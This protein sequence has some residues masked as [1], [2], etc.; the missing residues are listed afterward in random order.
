VAPG[1]EARFHYLDA[2]RAALMFMG[3]FVHSALGDD[4]VFRGI[5]HLSGLF[6][7]NGFFLI[8]G[9]FSSMLVLRYGPRL[10]VRRRLLSLGVPLLTAGAVCNPVAWWLIYNQYN[11]ALGFVDFLTGHGRTRHP[12]GPLTWHLQLWFL[13]SL[14]GYALATPSL[15][16]G[17]RRLAVARWFRRATAS[18]ARAQATL[19]GLVLAMTAV[20]E[21][22]Y[23]AVFVPVLGMTPVDYVLRETLLY[24]PFFAVGMSLF[25]DGQRLLG[26]F[27]RPAPALFAGA[28]LLVGLDT[29]HPIAPLTAPVVA[30]MVRALFAFA[31]VANLFAVASRLVTR[32]YRILRYGADAAFSVYLLHYVTIYAVAA[33]LGFGVNAAWPA[34]LLV[35]TLTLAVT[36]AAHHLLI[37]PSRV[38]SAVLNGRLPVGSATARRRPAAFAG[39]AAASLWEALWHVAATA[40]PWATGERARQP[41]RRG[42]HRARRRAPTV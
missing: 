22:L 19:L 23:R 6:R 17:W 5:A 38:L 7:M 1:G 20:D 41:A 26:D 29:L 2:L 35:A 9:F 42:R 11:P 8:S 28:G 37:R 39:G 4:P 36:L 40:G 3:V 27:A 18:P 24:L 30:A 21:E 15:F 16:V 32:E 10:M 34:L 14:L 13:V 31:V 12:A 33:L 25:L